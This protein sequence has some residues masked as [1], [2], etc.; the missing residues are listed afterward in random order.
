MTP[1][2]RQLKKTQAEYE[3]AEAVGAAAIWEHAAKVRLTSAG[4]HRAGS[5]HLTCGAL[6]KVV[7]M[8]HYAGDFWKV[9]NDL[10]EKSVALGGPL[11]TVLVENQETH[12]PGGKF[13]KTA[14]KLG[15]RVGSKGA[16][17]R[18][19]R[20]DTLKWIRG[21]PGWA[22]ELLDSSS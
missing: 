8:Y 18:R 9:L 21:H 1:K 2:D 11:I 22:A 13:F 20:R 19:Q 12:Q 15:F 17:V 5:S 14:E 10:C 6:A 16:F 4:E 3:R 7:G